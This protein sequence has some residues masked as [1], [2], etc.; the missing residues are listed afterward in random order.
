MASVH[1]ILIF[2]ARY[3]PE[4]MLPIIS[5]GGEPWLICLYILYGFM[6]DLFY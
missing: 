4:H 1:N 3:L 6:V 2:S 5:D